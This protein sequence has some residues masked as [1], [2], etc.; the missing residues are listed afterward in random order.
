MYAFSG[1]TVIF[2]S[3]CPRSPTERV[4]VYNDLS[5][6]CSLMSSV[7]ESIVCFADFTTQK[8]LFESFGI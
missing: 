3:Q 5:Y 1:C 8:K 2:D 7:L 6:T 4:T